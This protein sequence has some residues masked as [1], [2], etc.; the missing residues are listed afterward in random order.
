MRFAVA[1]HERVLTVADTHTGH[2]RAPKAAKR[3]TVKG[4]SSKSR[5]RLI[6]LL[7]QI[8]RPDEPVF[9][10]LTYRGFAVDFRTWKTH[11]HNFRRVLADDFPDYCGLWRLEFQERGAPHFHILAWLVREVV[12]AE[13]EAR[14]AQ[15][16]CRVIGQETA[17]NLEHG[18]TVEPVTDF[19]A[20][21]FYLSLYQ[22]KDSQDRKDINTGREW[23]VWKRERLGLQPIS[24][25]LFDGR[26][27][28]LFRRIIRRHY[29]SFLRRSGKGTTYTDADGKPVVRGY[30]RALRRPQGFTTFL[31]YQ[32]AA[33]LVR[34]IEEQPPF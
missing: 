32:H 6:R 7:A 21:A 24:K 16:W 34:W 30:L 20:C 8:S 22:A 27:F 5:M 26:E 4:I 18:C 23:G 1:L 11:L 25:T 12:L 19:R 33:K 13:V 29:V 9:I 15:V 3:G 17:A 2:S 14:L 28:N 10:T 31:P